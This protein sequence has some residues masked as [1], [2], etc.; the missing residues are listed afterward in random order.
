MAAMYLLNSVGVNTSQG[1]MQY[2]A[3]RLITTD[4]EQT[5][6][7]GAGGRLWPATDTK[8]AEAAQKVMN[9]RYYRGIDDHLSTQIM[10]LAAQEVLLDR[11][12]GYGS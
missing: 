2:P 3:G 5:A 12:T 1:V 9:L 11:G 10:V 8:V 7:A 4:E 6:I